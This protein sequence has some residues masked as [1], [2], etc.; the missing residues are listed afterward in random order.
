METLK[1]K[2]KLN[3]E[4]KMKMSF[5]LALLCLGLSLT[6]ANAQVGM[7]TNNPNKDAVLDLNRTDGTSEKGLLLPKVEL[8]A[9]NSSLPLTTNVAGMHVWNTATA[10]FGATAVIPGEY[11]NDGTKWVRVASADNTWLQDGNNNGSLKSIGTNDTFDLPIQTNGTEK[12]RVTSDGNIGIGTSA[13]TTKLEINSSTTNTSGLKFTNL[14]AATPISA[15]AT[16][17]VDSSGNVV[18]VNGNAFIASTGSA[19]LG[20]SLVLPN[21]TAKP[22]LVSITLPMPGTYLITYTIRAQFTTMPSTTL[23]YYSTWGIGYLSKS[24][25]VASKLPNSEI[26]L[27]CSLS[28]SFFAGTGG[29]YS[30]TYIYTVPSGSQT[31]YLGVEN[32]LA[33]TSSMSLQDNADG[34][35]NISYVKITP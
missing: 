34:R 13:P 10:G 15:G 30:G 20:T 12:M 33:S 5:K 31:I 17:G 22:N 16:L 2:N 3:K 24:G 11:F 35:T 32:A 9:T 21:G 8:T 28:S 26:L 25:T 1:N 14:N 23:S 7:P 18:T 29:N 27:A 4:K 19:S 6:Y